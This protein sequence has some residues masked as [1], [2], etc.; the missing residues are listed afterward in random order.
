M[1]IP[2]KFLPLRAST[3]VSAASYRAARSSVMLYFFFKFLDTKYMAAAPAYFT[4]NLSVK[5]KFPALP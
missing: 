2:R 1:N 5:L 4:V 3:H